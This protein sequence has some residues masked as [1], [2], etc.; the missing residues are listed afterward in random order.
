[1]YVYHTLVKQALLPPAHHWLRAA[2]SLPGNS[3]L[4]SALFGFP[5]GLALSACPPLLLPVASFPTSFRAAAPLALGPPGAQDPPDLNPHPSSERLR[6]P[7]SR[8][9]RRLSTSLPDRESKPWL[10][11]RP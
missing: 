6:T 4:S 8:G 5:V 11:Y 2:S 3:L 1:M 7:C 9:L 10:C